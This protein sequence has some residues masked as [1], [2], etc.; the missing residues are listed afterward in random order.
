MTDTLPY[1]SW[2][3]PI[4]PSDLVGAGS[5]AAD[6]R[7]DGADVLFL[8]TTA[9][10]G[11]RVVLCRRAPDGVVSEVSPEWMSVRSRVHEYG[12]GAWAVRG[13]VVLA[14]DF[15]TQRLWRLDG[16]PQPLTPAVEGAAVRWA[17]MEIDLDR[18]A[19]F[20]V[21]ED[22][23][24]DA[25][26][27]VTTLVRLSLSEETWGEIVVDGRRRELPRPPDDRAG[28]PSSPD[29]FSDPV[30]S[31]DGTRLAW[32]Q[33]SHPAMPWS[34]ASVWVGDLDEVGDV[35]AS[36]RLGPAGG[37]SFEP[38]WVDADRL[39][40][41]AEP[42]GWVLPHVAAAD[43]SAAA[44]ALAVDGIE[45][46][47]PAWM[48]RTRSMAATVD[49]TLVAVCHVDRTVRLAAI[50]PSGSKKPT[51]L[52]PPLAYAAG[53]AAFADGVVLQAGLPDL[54]QTVATVSEAGLTVL[55]EIGRR[56]PEEC[57][58]VAEPVSW[59]G[60]DGASAFGFLY[61]PV[62]PGVTAPDDELPPL[63]VTAHGGPTSAAI[64]V[65][66]SAVA[67]FTS[68]G[69]AVLDVDYAGSTGFGRA[70]R[71]RLDG[72][73]G[74]ADIEDCV[75]GAR[76]LADEGIVD[77][78]RL[79][80]RGGSAG[81]FVVLAAL[82]FHD[83]FSAGISLFGVADLALL[84]EETHKFESRYLDG[85][86][87]PYPA[88]KATYDARSPLHHVEG[89]DQPL[90]LLQGSEDRVVPPSQAQV[91]HAAL[92][93]DGKPVALV[94]FEGEGHG[95]REPA[96]IIRAAELETSFLGQA[97]GY[98][99]ADAPEKVVIENR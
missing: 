82:A 45:Y 8:R 38:V 43:G 19:C 76:H 20:A 31:P 15:S 97:W 3:S 50:D 92:A 56:P 86:V 94:M 36:R 60:Y 5:V 46:G 79:G 77:G 33:W 22:H 81:G 64:A 70:Y 35:V 88:S 68:R 53:L 1:G 7:A 63:V 69:I 10:T 78:D 58:P 2:P 12:G 32:A 37:A 72:T 34:G 73:W 59:T 14:V 51:Y 27:P 23:R 96:S 52:G 6:V 66:R 28:D 93:R 65:P 13:G 16:E 18:G 29:F 80:I 75:A 30:L 74:L 54:G 49:G 39:A 55:E 89:I 57:T 83:V 90:L 40:F 67:Y 17:A 47:G 61:R 95:F 71:E 84:A 48:I 9:E 91:M 85:L 26:E 41:L 62:H 11:A 4:S 24:D 99:P 21:R 98:A 44:V 87:G 42:G 25:A